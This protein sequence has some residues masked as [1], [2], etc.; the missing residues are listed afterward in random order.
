M[1]SSTDADRRPTGSYANRQR[2]LRLQ[3]LDARR[4]GDTE[5]A[6]R[7]CRRLDNLF[8]ARAHHR[9]GDPE[10]RRL[11]RLPWEGAA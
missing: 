6:R 11:R 10:T 1:N 2:A 5:Q 9:A 4:R 3:L 7:V 8:V